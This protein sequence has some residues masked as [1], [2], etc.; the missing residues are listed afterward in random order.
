MRIRFFKRVE[1]KPGKRSGP[2]ACSV[3]LYWET[4]PHTGTRAA[5]LSNG[6]T[7]SNTLPP[8]FS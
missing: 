2:C 3:A 6:H 1:I 5:E 4:T 7:A 8:T